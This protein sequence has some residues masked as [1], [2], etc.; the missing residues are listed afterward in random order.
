MDKKASY[1]KG[2]CAILVFVLCFPNWM[3]PLFVQAESAPSVGSYLAERWA[4][5]VEGAVAAEPVIGIDGTV[6]VLTK[7][8][9][10][11]ALSP[12]G[13]PLW[14]AVVRPM[15]EEYEDE[16]GQVLL[17]TD[18]VIYVSSSGNLYAFQADGTKKW[19][20]ETTYSRFDK[21]ELQ[22]NGLIYIKLNNSSMLALRLDGTKALERSDIS[23]LVKYKGLSE[24][25]IYATSYSLITNIVG[26]KLALETTTYAEELNTNG[27]TRWKVKLNATSS[28]NSPSVDKDGNL[29]VFA[30]PSGLGNQPQTPSYVKSRQPTEVKVISEGVVRRTYSLTGR[31]EAPILFDENNNAY[32]VTLDAVVSK[33]DSSGKLIWK[34]QLD[35]RTNLIER[36]TVMHLEKDGA[37]LFYSTLLRYEKSENTS[38]ERSELY[39]LELQRISEDGKLISSTVIK[40][41]KPVVWFD[42]GMMLS[43]G[44]NKLIFSDLQMEKSV[45]FDVSSTFH[46]TFVDK[47]QIYMGTKSGRVIALELKN[48]TNERDVVSLSFGNIYTQFQVGTISALQASA[49]YADGKEQTNPVGIIYRTSNDKIAYF[50]KAGFHAAAPGEV[51]VTAEYLKVKTTIKVTVNGNPNTSK[52]E[53]IY[54]ANLNKKWS[55]VL[56]AL[57]T[58]ENEKYLEP[59]IS[60]E[61]S[62]YALSSQGKIT[63]VSSDGKLRWQHDMNEIVAKPPV[64]G[65]DARLYVGTNT[66]QLV[67]YELASGKQML[68]QNIAVGQFSTLLGWDRF[69][70]RYT[71]FSISSSNRMARSESSTLQATDISDAVRWT[72]PLNGEIVHD[73]LVLNSEGDTVYVVTKNTETVG[74]VADYPMAMVTFRSIGTLY[75][76]DALSGNIRWKYDLGKSDST[77][78]K[79]V[80]LQ[81]GTIVAASSQGTVSAVDADGNLKWKNNFKFYL[82]AAPIISKDHI[83]MFRHRVVEGLTEG[84]N[85][86]QFMNL[87]DYPET[88][89]QMQNEW[90]F[91]I[92]DTAIATRNRQSVASYDAAGKMKWRVD[93]AGDKSVASGVTDGYQVAV[94]DHVNELSL[95][96]ITVTRSSDVLFY[97]MKLHWAREAVEKLVEA[98]VVSGFP[99]GTY[100]PNAAVTREQFLSMLSKKLNTT[101]RETE[102]AFTDVAKDRWSRA[103]IE[104]AWADGWIDA[105]AYGSTFKPADPVTREEVTVWTAK[106]L[107]LTEKVDGLAKVFDLSSIKAS[108]RGLVG[109]VIDA[110]IINGYEDGSFKPLATLTRAEAAVL[111]SRVKR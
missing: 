56:P 93:L 32:I 13:K 72:T 43:D 78:Y 60:A 64:L 83:T 26:G 68:N 69:G 77:F 74:E 35:D 91:T 97:D 24:D 38:Y 10:F 3:A 109:A 101:L 6:Y 20:Y 89:N 46:L 111:L 52:P 73:E 39:K 59:I 85:S 82:Q 21:V 100:R 17:G 50:D 54:S 67:S 75:A 44:Y 90:L 25:K 79:P 106:A 88:I 41:E 8:G 40:N 61:G 84:E 16:K 34:L 107:K 42:N 18:G 55:F 49:K 1:R 110:G 22:R 19:E 76:I 28:Y 87:Q 57:E 86:I 108:N 11:Y 48:I 58:S 66:G 62:V 33:F 51:E 71:G 102:L 96:D 37:L 98:G 105:T 4:L 29:M 23:G 36:G 15:S 47:N 80:L 70:N 99:D 12:T 63:A 30:E 103:I 95:F 9:K 94:I 7:K 31:T 27:S 45:E 5:N 2:I 81:D 65:P 104:S 92:K 14:T 53:P